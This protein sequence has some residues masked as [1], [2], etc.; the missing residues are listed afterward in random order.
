MFTIIGD[1]WRTS[2][3]NQNQRADRF[4][5]SY[6]SVGNINE[7]IRVDVFMT[8][9]EFLEKMMP[10]MEECKDNEFLR[11]MTG[12]LF[13]YV[14][15]EVMKDKKYENEQFAHVEI[16]SAYGK[17]IFIIDFERLNEADT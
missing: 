4:S 16:E 13:S 5:V 7:C 17:T 3:E 6:C 2:N 10:I 8:R 15:A 14:A 9:D 11:F 1:N 12:F